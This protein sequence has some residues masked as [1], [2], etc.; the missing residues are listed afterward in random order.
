MKKDDLNSLTVER[1]LTIVYGNDTG[2]LN[3]Q[4]DRYEKLLT[5][6]EANF[7][8]ADVQLFSTPGRTE[9]SGNHTDHNRGRVLAGSITLDAIAAAAENGQEKAVLYSEGYAK[10]FSVDLNALDVN[11]TEF[12]TTTSLIRGVAA[13]FRMLGLQIGGFNAM[14]SS[15]VLPGSGLSSSAAIE[16]LIGTIFNG[17]FND[18]KIAPE[19]LAKIGQYAENVFFGKP[20]GLMDQVA[21]AVGGIVTIDFQNPEQPDI[22]KVNFD[23]TAQSY[24]LVIVDTGGNHADLTDNYADIP[25]EM[26][27][28]AAHFGKTVCRKISR[29]EILGDIENLRKSVGDR[30][31][32]RALHFLDE[33]DRVEKQVAALEGNNLPKFLNWV[34]SSGNSSFRWLQNIYAPQNPAEQGVSLALMV[35]ERFLA[36]KA[37]GACRV[38]GGGFAG[39]IQAFVNQADVPDYCREMEQLFGAGAALPLSI[40]S[41]G[42]VHLNRL[43]G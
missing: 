30:A 32:L 5:E 8:A 24:Q 33:N 41:L 28:V 16:V 7:G 40:R 38:H 11:E 2:K 4:R 17:L 3:I 14:I 22:R 31:V 23:F 20:C 43:T 25:R 37:A 27:A 1:W 19:T 9:I 21:C 26:K 18:G 29:G 10:P 34:R 36:I 15:D 35:S 13:R 6:F 12:G 42:T 39:T